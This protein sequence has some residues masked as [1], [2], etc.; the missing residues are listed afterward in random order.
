MIDTQAYE[1]EETRGDDVVDERPKFRATVKMEIQTKG[2]AP[3]SDARVE[4]LSDRIYG[5]T[6]EQEERIHVR[7]DELEPIS[8]RAAFGRQLGRE[9]CRDE[10]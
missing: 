7:E 5:K 4:E 6:L 9:R 3:H 10:S 8:V 1:N 2:D